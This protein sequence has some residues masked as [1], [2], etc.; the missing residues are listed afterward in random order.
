MATTIT[1][2][3]SLSWHLHGATEADVSTLIDHCGMIYGV[4]VKQED[5]AATRKCHGDDTDLVVFEGSA[6]TPAGMVTCRLFVRY[7]DRH[8]PAPM[9]TMIAL[10]PD[11][12]MAEAQVIAKPF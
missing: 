4:H 2:L 9:P 10:V 5:P 1:A 11:D 3:H 7:L 12:L 8:Q 6:P